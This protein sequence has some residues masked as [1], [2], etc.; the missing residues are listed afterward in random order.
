MPAGTRLEA[1]GGRRL[2][3]HGLRIAARHADVHPPRHPGRGDP[4]GTVTLF[5]PEVADGTVQAVDDRLDGRVVLR[6]T[7]GDDPDDGDRVGGRRRGGLRRHRL[8]RRLE[9]G[10]AAHLAGRGHAADL[11]GVVGR[12]P[13]HDLH[14]GPGRDAFE[15]GGL[16]PHRVALVGTHPAVGLPTRRGGGLGGVVVDRR[17]HQLTDDGVPGRHVVVGR[18]DGETT[19]QRQG[20]GRRQGGDQWPHGRQPASE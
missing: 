12:R 15:L 7:G 10:Q 16:D 3:E 18:G 4:D 14:L 6:L 9:N 19:E 5:A 1:G 2:V 8:G 20:D 17:P 13:Q 11:S